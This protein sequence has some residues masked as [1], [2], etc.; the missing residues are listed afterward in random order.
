MQSHERM[1]SKGPCSSASFAASSRSHE[2]TSVVIPLHPSSRQQVAATPC[3]WAEQ[4][5]KPVAREGGGE[6]G[7]EERDELR[8][9]REEH[10][11][12]HQAAAHPRDACAASQLDHVRPAL[13]VEV[14]GWGVWC[15][16]EV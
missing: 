8:L 16:V 7:V 12:A 10:L 4:G 9:F 5:C 2:S 6:V 13:R 11:G 15:R 1:R 3:R 14:D